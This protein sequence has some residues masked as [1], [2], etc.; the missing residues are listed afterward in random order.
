MF[1]FEVYIVSAFISV[2]I[3]PRP[4]YFHCAGSM[5]AIK[6]YGGFETLNFIQYYEAF[7][8]YGSIYEQEI[9]ICIHHI[10]D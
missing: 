3:S 1:V 5:Q 4:L 2:S 10:I 9:R 8:I 6:Y 7:L